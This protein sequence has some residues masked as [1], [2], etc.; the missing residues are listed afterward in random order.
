MHAVDDRIEWLERGWPLR[1]DGT[2][3]TELAGEH[4]LFAMSEGLLVLGSDVRNDVF[5]SRG[6]VWNGL[7]QRFD[8]ALW[9]SEFPGC[10]VLRSEPRLDKALGRS[11]VLGLVERRREPSGRPFTRCLWLVLPRQWG[12]EL[13]ARKA[14]AACELLLHHRGR[15]GAP[16]RTSALR[17]AHESGALH[18]PPLDR[19][20]GLVRALEPATP[21]ELLASLVE[22]QQRLDSGSAWRSKGLAIFCAPELVGEFSLALTVEH[23]LLRTDWQAPVPFHGVASAA[24]SQRAAIVVPEPRLATPPPMTTVQRPAA[25]RDEPSRGPVRLAFGLMLGMQALQLLVTLYPTSATEVKP[26]RDADPMPSSSVLPT[27]VPAPMEERGPGLFWQE[28]G[29]SAIWMPS[30]GHETGEMRGTEVAATEVFEQ[31]ERSDVP[32]VVVGFASH[33]DCQAADSQ[34]RHDAERVV[35]ELNLDPSTEIIVV[36]RRTQALLPIVELEAG[37]LVLPGD[38]ADGWRAIATVDCGDPVWPTHRTSSSVEPMPTKP[39]S[40]QNRPSKK[41]DSSATGAKK[42]SNVRDPDETAPDGSP[43]SIAGE[44]KAANSPST[45][46][47]KA[48]A[49]K[50]DAPK[51]DAT[52]SGAQQPATQKPGTQ[53]TDKG[54]KPSTQKS[55][56][57]K[58]SGN[59]KKSGKKGE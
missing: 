39:A 51:S 33:T 47:A 3:D 40:K 20:G 41:T 21:A 4:G 48:D 30:R 49:P 7:G 1:E 31:L 19:G 27:K 15:P 34:A 58:K 26:D 14:H 45:D 36:G 10:I 44:A 57:D 52:K 12:M 59:D 28:L 8:D 29:R 6:G 18:L 11:L 5:S 16:A 53:K 42:P 37:V 25:R 55:G 17:V 13:D 43:S 9:P 35:M 24:R 38:E 56:S 54:T 2:C 22:L 23:T 46:G 32:L 50:A